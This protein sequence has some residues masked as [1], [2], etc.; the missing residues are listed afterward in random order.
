MGTVQPVSLRASP[1]D[2][3]TWAR[4]VMDFL[5]LEFTENQRSV[6]L[7]PVADLASHMLSHLL[8]ASTLL[9]LLI[10]LYLVLITIARNPGGK[11]TPQESAHPSPN[12]NRLQKIR[13]LLDEAITKRSQSALKHLVRN[14]YPW[15]YP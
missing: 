7:E 8:I 2:C 6:E 11:K 4:Q 5:S 13:E 12:I 9:H 3:A 14:F 10:Y 15:H 1:V